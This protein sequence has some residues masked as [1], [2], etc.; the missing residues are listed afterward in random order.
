MFMSIIV[1]AVKP[2]DYF[3]NNTFTDK[4]PTTSKFIL[5]R[6]FYTMKKMREYSFIIITYMKNFTN[7]IFHARDTSR[8]SAS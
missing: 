2:S 3:L 4:K 5:A 1:D 6:I 7:L 8:P